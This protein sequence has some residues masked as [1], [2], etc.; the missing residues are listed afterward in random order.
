VSVPL[1]HGGAGG[2]IVE[3]TLVLSIVLVFAA[4]W[5]RTRNASADDAEQ[6]P[7]GDAGV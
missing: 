4:V 6:G 7:K 3:I 2:A 1:A 5:R